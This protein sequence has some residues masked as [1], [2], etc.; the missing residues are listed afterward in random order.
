MTPQ[1][2]AKESESSQQ[3]AFFCYCAVAYRHGFALADY[4]CSGYDIE[5]VKANLED[6]F[7]VGIP[8]LEF[9]HAIPNGGLRDKKTASGLRAEG[10]KKGVAD[11]CLPC[12]NGTYNALY[13][14]MKKPSLKPKSEGRKGG[15][16]DDQIKFKN[17]CKKAC[18]SFVVC[19]SYI[20]AIEVIKKYL[21]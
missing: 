12:S 14:E 4:W 21:T 1:Q 20:E 13:I 8:Q 7:I 16:S 10:V 11:I 15:L 2:I 19:Y 18:N 9:I 5:T 6:E 3:K 17:Y